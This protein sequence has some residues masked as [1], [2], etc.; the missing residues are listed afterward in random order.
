MGDEIDIA[1][2]EIVKEHGNLDSE[3]KVTSF[4]DK[5]KLDAKL[6]YDVWSESY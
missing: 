1:L 2:R 6:Q 3:E 4:I 5:M